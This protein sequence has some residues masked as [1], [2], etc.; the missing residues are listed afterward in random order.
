[1]SSVEFLPINTQNDFAQ[2]LK[3]LCDT[4]VCSY[5]TADELEKIGG[6]DGYRSW[7]ES[8][9]VSS[10]ESAVHVWRKDK[11]V[12]QIEMRVAESRNVCVVNL[13]YLIP[14]ER[15]GELG[16]A[17]QA[18]IFEYLRRNHI[19]TGRLS[20]SPGNS[21]AVSYYKKHGWKDL[22]PRHDRS[23]VHLMEIHIG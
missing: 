21:R 17:L 4:F 14:E 9:I 23:Y 8:L 10:P 11:I 3:F 20:V 6:P 16:G 7:L 22:G 19:E 12:G 2:C 1:M 18:Y 5:G 15:G 13:C